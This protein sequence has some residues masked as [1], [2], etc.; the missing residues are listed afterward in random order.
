MAATTLD[1]GNIYITDAPS[2]EI[3]TTQ[4]NTGYTVIK[5]E[6]QKID[7]NYNNP[8]VKIAIPVSG[9]N[10]ATKTAH[11]FIIDLKRIGEA[12]SVQGFLADESTERAFTKRENLITLGK[13]KGELSVIWGLTNHQTAFKAKESAVLRG[14]FIE[15]MMFTETPG[16][17]GESLTA[18]VSANEC[19]SERNIAI[20]I[21]LVRG[22]DVVTG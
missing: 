9:G 6:T 12:I 5:I 8:V 18:D 19:A 20:Q 10:R 22:K 14:V 11:S 15:K 16:F 4:I 7:Y 2:S 1:A 3:T 17:V 21:T 13:T